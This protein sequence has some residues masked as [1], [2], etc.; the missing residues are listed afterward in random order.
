MN[1]NKI[2]IANKC[3]MA[4]QRVVSTEDGQ[5]LAQEYGIQFFEASAK[6]NLNVEKAFVSIAHESMERLLAD[7]GTSG[8]GAGAGKKIQNP[9]GGSAA[10]GASGGGGCCK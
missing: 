5:R 10:A 7:G 2:L 9:A 8:T 4:D 1:V 3:D 6:Q